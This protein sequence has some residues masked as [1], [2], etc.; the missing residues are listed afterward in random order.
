MTPAARTRIRFPEVDA[1]ETLNDFIRTGGL[2]NGV[3][4]FD[5]GSWP[6]NRRHAPGVCSRPTGGAGDKLHP[7][8][9]GYLAMGMAVDIDAL[10][11]KAALK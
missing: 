11:S 3:A 9:L 6:A 5:K 4:D 10:L 2:F 8:R 7:N 1:N